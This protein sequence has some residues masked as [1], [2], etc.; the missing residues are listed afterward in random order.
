MSIPGQDTSPGSGWATCVR[1][2]MDF[3]FYINDSVSLSHSLALE[4]IKRH[5]PGCGL[6]KNTQKKPEQV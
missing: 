3:V 6:K 4:S 1:K 5:I 2:P